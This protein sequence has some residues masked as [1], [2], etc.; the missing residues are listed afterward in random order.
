MAI[1]RREIHRTHDEYGVI[2]V[3]DDR[4]KRYL[5]FRDQTKQSKAVCSKHTP[6]DLQ[7]GYTRVMLLPLLFL[8]NPKTALILGLGAG[9]LAT[10][11]HHNVNH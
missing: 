10:C 9:S 3:Y 2:D 7:C 1:P 6:A 11:L 4:E 5:A 8:S